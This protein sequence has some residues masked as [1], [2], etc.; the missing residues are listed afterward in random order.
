MTFY[1]KS[2]HEKWLNLNVFLSSKQQV[3]LLFSFKLSFPNSIKSGQRFTL[4]LSKTKTNQ[5]N[6]SINSWIAS[7]SALAKKIITKDFFVLND[8]ASIEE[9]KSKVSLK[10]IRVIYNKSASKND[11]LKKYEVGFMHITNRDRFK[12]KRP[13]FSFI[14]H[15]KIPTYSNRIWTR[16]ILTKNP[17]WI[18]LDIL[19]NQTYGAGWSDNKF[20]LQEMLQLAIKLEN[21][22]L[23]FSGI[24]DRQITIWEAIHKVAR[25]ARCIPL[26][27]GSL[28]R[29][30]HLE[31]Q[32][33]PMAMFS[34]ENIVANSFNINYNL[35]NEDTPDGINLKFL[36]PITLDVKHILKGPKDTFNRDI[37]DRPTQPKDIDFFGCDSSEQAQK[38]AV[39][40][41][42]NNYFSRKTYKFKTE[43]E[44]HLPIVGDLIA[45]SHDLL[46][47]ENESG[48]VIGAELS[49]DHEEIILKL[50]KDL[51]WET[52]PAKQK[53]VTAPDLAAGNIPVE[54]NISFNN[55]KGYYKAMFRCS[56]HPIFS[57][58]II[59]KPHGD[60]SKQRLSV[61]DTQAIIEFRNTQGT[62]HDKEINVY[63]GDQKEKTMFIFSQQE[64]NQYPL[65]VL[66][67]AVK[68]SGKGQVQIE[69]ISTS[70][71][72]YD[73]GNPL[74]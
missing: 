49:P 28:F 30:I 44:G 73:V 69:A 46:P 36:D 51:K 34:P 42:R 33:I 8:T 15:R 13:K 20:D 63:F 29:L 40:L 57:N 45:I 50:D 19:K 14:V 60:F 31:H 53:W 17:V 7:S 43:L 62:V 55:L 18:I 6:S 12:F 27:Q 10:N 2:I 26:M 47:M 4:I 38:E 22:A 21:K 37:G 64:R 41:A 16:P 1:Y 3:T 56:P 5:I 11:F 23:L 65:H 48:R 54:G 68:A 67:K 39:Y 58:K 9:D 72:I 35:P 66:V 74:P 70:K 52:D 32:E 59:I 71:H 25:V 61:S 24:F